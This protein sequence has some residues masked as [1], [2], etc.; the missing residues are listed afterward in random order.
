M[1]NILDDTL[2]IQKDLKI[3]HKG[4]GELWCIICTMN[5]CAAMK[6]SELFLYATWRNNQDNVG[7]GEDRQTKRQCTLHDSMSK[8]F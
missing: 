8:D 6:M 1:V 4:N 3:Y 5:Y 7:E 2:Q